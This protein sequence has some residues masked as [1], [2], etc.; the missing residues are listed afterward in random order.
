MLLVVRVVCGVI[1]VLAIPWVVVFTIIRF[2]LLS[3]P[4]IVATLYAGGSRGRTIDGV[5]WVFPTVGAGLVCGYLLGCVRPRYVIMAI[6]LTSAASFCNMW[7]LRVPTATW[8][9]QFLPKPDHMVARAVKVVLWT[10]A[11]FLFGHGAYRSWENAKGASRMS[12]ERR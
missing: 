5:L 1:A 2:D 3:N 8:A 11:A 10:G 4:Y 9:V 12:G 6:L 7:G